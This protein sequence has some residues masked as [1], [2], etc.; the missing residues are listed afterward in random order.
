MMED[1]MRPNGVSI[2]AVKSYWDARPCNIR[3]SASPV[4]SRR[5][6]DEVERRKYFVEPHIPAFADFA[7]WAGKRVLEIGCGIGTD[8]V[9]FAR[10]GADY[11]GVE[12]SEASLALTRQRLDVYGLRGALYRGNAEE[13]SAFLPVERFDLIYSFGVVHHTPHPERVVQQVTAYMGP[14]SELRLMMYAKNS[15]KDIMIEAGLEQP[16]AE[17]GC[18]IARTYTQEELRHLLDGFTILEMRQ[19]HIFP[20]VVEKYVKYEYEVSPWFRAMPDGMFRALERRLG[21][22]TL[23]RCALAAPTNGG[24]HR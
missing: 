3:H 8:A 1:T 6:F 5:Y 24:S 13:L 22:H 18:P 10:A 14:H 16:E 17:A 19:A 21:W 15:W 2:D 20:Y 7:R 11:T 4:G 12:L 9:G 23:I